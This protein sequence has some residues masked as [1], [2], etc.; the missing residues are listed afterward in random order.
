[1]NSH[2]SI[3]DWGEPTLQSQCLL[4][5]EG[6]KNETVG[7][8]MVEEEEV[9]KEKMKRRKHLQL[10]HLRRRPFRL[11]EKKKRIENKV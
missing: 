11:K 4:E 5:F 6:R 8:E 7:E 9:K 10:V 2:R 3:F 1:M